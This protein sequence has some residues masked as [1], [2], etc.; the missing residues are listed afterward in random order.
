MR[1]FGLACGMALAAAAC[2]PA[3]ANVASTLALEIRIDQAAPGATN[4]EGT[5][6]VGMRADRP[7]NGP[8][9]HLL[10][11]G[12]RALPEGASV[13]VRVGGPVQLQ[14]S[15][16]VAA[17]AFG[18]LDRQLAWTA[19]G[20]E[21]EAE[22]GWMIRERG[23]AQIPADPTLQAVV[24]E[25]DGGVTA[26]RLAGGPTVS[27]EIDTAAGTWRCDGPGAQVSAPWWLTRGETS[28]VLAV[29]ERVERHRT[30][31]GLEVVGRVR[32]RVPVD[33]AATSGLQARNGV[34]S[35]A[36]G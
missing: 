12:L 4:A 19:V 18:V 25:L 14:S 27:L 16:G 24:L 36:R 28:G 20:L 33:A 5:V 30:A 22:G 32:V 15:D 8:G 9:C 3:P 21:A 35:G 1:R 13:A 11:T 17:G 34:W 23:A 29:V 10:P 2:D 31:D 26:H 6:Q 7:D